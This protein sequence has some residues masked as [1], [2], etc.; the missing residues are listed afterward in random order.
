[1]AYT[2][3]I[4]VE[5]LVPLLGDPQTVVVDCRFSLADPAAGEQQYAEGHVPGAVYAHLDRDLSSA[6]TETSGRHPLPVPAELA[7]TLANWGID[8]SKQVVAYDESGSAFAARFWWVAKWLGLKN[9]AVLDGGL[10]AWKAAGQPVSTEVSKLTPTTFTPEPNRSMW[11][12]TDD[13]QAGLASGEMLL[14]D[15]RGATR[16]SGEEEPI[17][18]VAGHVPGAVNRS[19]VENLNEAGEFRSPAELAERFDELIGNRETGSVVHMCGSG[20]TACVNL[21]ACEL[22]GHHGTK[23]YPGSWSEWIRDSKRGVATNC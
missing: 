22:A 15:A 12:S 18:P 5:Q 4:T 14:V 10:A 19:Q 17:D 13:V 9:V 1:M 21:L 6:A 8:A 2:T 7:A 3:L 16:Y 23:L 20:V 11:L